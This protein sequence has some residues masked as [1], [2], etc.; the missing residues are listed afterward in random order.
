MEEKTNNQQLLITKEPVLQKIVS[1]VFGFFIMGIGIINLFWG[2][3]GGLGISVILLSLIYIMPLNRIFYK[4]FGSFIPI[5][6]ILKVVLG[7]II[8][9]L[10][11][12][13]G[14]LSNKIG[15]MLN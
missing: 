15:M 3:D 7:L 9:W 2:N 12:E 8:L 13:I 6:G 5:S 14:D 1:I 4:I 10:T 11:L